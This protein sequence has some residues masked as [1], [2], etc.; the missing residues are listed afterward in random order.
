MTQSNHITGGTVFTGIFASLWDINIFS[1]FNLLLVVWFASV[2]PDIDHT[3]SPIG[4]LFYPISR[5]I[6]KKF[7]HRTITHSIVF[8]LSAILI[9]RAIFPFDFFLVFSF[10]LISHLIFDMVTVQGVPLFYPFKK[11]PCVLPANPEARI[12]SGNTRS[13][14]TAFVLF[15]FCGSFC[16]PLMVNGFWMTFNQTLGSQKQLVSEFKRSDQILLVEYDFRRDFEMVSGVG[17]CLS[18][19]ESQIVF[20]DT[21]TSHF[22]HMTKG[23][24]PKGFTPHFTAYSSLDAISKEIDITGYSLSQLDSLT[25][26]SPIL[27]ANIFCS[28]NISCTLDNITLSGQHFQGNYL[29]QIVLAESKQDNQAVK[30]KLIQ[31]DQLTENYKIELRKYNEDLEQIEILKR[32]YITA[33]DF[34]KS[35][36]NKSIAEIRPQ[37]PDIRT[38]QNKTQILQEEIKYLTHS[39]QQLQLFGN[40]KIITL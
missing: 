21:A 23:D 5:Y 33:S 32:E 35:T 16:Y 22:V 20:L 26:S 3:K 36:I 39:N 24:V 4:K 31:L 2:L 7:G 29:N 1:D 13:E 17:Y 30:I 27:S 14:L 6:D 19:N 38:Y 25:S 11:N 15:I 18:A 9:F 40:I 34:R 12:R 10:G 28:Q 37:I 8:V